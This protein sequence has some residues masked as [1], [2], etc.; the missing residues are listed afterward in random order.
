MSAEGSF[1]PVHVE[2]EG[3]VRVGLPPER[4]LELFTPRGEELW[5]PGWKPEYLHPRDGSITDG[6][7]FT[8]RADG[9]TTYWLVTRWDPAALTARYARI[10]PALHAADVEIRCSADDDGTAVTVRYRLTALTDEGAAA[11]EEW[12]AGWFA[13][14]METWESLL[15][16]SLGQDRPR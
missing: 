13:E 10:T 8:T 1:E 3:T 14:H 2:R 11:V 6:A 16:D 12:T 7:V 5:V 9:H 15:V 4:A